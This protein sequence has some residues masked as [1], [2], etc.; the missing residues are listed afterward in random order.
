MKKFVFYFLLASLVLVNIFAQAQPSLTLHSP[1][2]PHNQLKA[3][4]KIESRV[5][6]YQGKQHTSV[7]PA[8]RESAKDTITSFMNHYHRRFE[9]LLQ[10]RTQFNDLADWYPDTVHINKVYVQRLEVNKPFLTYLSQFLACSTLFVKA[11][12]TTYQQDELMLVASRFFLCDQVRPDT[13]VS[14]HVCIGLNGMKEVNWTKDYTL[15]EAFCFEA[16]FDKM[17]SKNLDETRYM[18]QFLKAVDESTRKYRPFMRTKDHLLEQV[19]GDVFRTMQ[20]DLI[21]KKRLLDYYHQHAAS[22][23]FTI[24]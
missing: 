18:D 14:W 4:F 21:L 1:T 10:N 22:L 3:H 12:P 24:L 17:F 11:K 16:I 15:L 5:V 6:E 9:Y 23:P 20:T 2:I 7:Y 8:L 19:K 13:T